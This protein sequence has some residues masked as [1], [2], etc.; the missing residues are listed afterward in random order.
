MRKQFYQTALGNCYGLKLPKPEMLIA[1][2]ER[3][4]I[5][6]FSIIFGTLSLPVE[7]FFAR[8]G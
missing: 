2:Y 8:R 4:F 7:R 1:V 6:S 3:N 5:L